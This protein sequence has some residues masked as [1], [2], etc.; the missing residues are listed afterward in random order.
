M[1]NDPL[2]LPDISAEQRPDNAHGAD[3]LHG[4]HGSDDAQ[5]AEYEAI[6]AEIAGT[7]RGR[8]VPERTRQTQSCRRYGSAGQFAGARRSG[9]ARR[10]DSGGG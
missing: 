1:A 3:N 2:P 8:L 9:D 4:A 6:H 10:L 5:E 7:E